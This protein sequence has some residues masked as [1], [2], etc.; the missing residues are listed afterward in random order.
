M[1]ALPRDIRL[2]AVYGTRPQP[3]S[4][5]DATSLCFPAVLSKDR[6][7][8][9]CSFLSFFAHFYIKGSHGKS[10]YGWGRRLSSMRQSRAK[11]GL[12]RALRDRCGAVLNF[13]VFAG[14]GNAAKVRAR[15]FRKPRAKRVLLHLYGSLRRAGVR[16]ATRGVFF[17]KP[18]VKRVATRRMS[19]C[20]VWLR[21]L[22]NRTFT[23][24]AICRKSCL[25]C[26]GVA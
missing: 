18:C 21:C 6:V 25:A 7:S 4:G 12:A 3:S 13:S 17:R 10:L 5:F 22:D 11:C 15:F 26:H 19:P 24:M 1:L 20:R 14:R 2:T 9:F 23:A 8:M 16:A